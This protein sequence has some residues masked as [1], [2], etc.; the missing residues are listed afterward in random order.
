MAVTNYYWDGDSYLEE[1][2]E[3][4]LVTVDYSLFWS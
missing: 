2:D 4:G 3:L 1:Y